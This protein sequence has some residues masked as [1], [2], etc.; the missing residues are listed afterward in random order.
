MEFEL[1]GARKCWS[2]AESGQISRETCDQFSDPSV[3]VNF[4][5]H[6]GS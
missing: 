2:R 1:A 6:G 3:T 4:A 5:G